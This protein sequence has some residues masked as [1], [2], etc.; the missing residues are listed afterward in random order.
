MRIILK[1]RRLLLLKASPVSE[2]PPHT[3]FCA[4]LRGKAAPR[5]LR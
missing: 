4:L 3:P 2:F 5:E 1:M